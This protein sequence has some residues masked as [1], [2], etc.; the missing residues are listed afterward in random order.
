MRG[1]LSTFL[2]WPR[3]QR[4]RTD[5]YWRA[6]PEQ[7]ARQNPLL[8]WASDLLAEP[9]SDHPSTRT[10]R[11]KPRTPPRIV[12]SRPTHWRVHSRAWKTFHTD[13]QSESIFPLPADVVGLTRH[14]PKRFAPRCSVARSQPLC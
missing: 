4:L 2:R 8:E 11:A 12:P 10:I 3:Y 7:V 6:V 9:L 1:A 5:K 13:A 14:G